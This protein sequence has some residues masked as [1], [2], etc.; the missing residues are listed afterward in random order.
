M[1]RGKR[2]GLGLVD[3]Y[4][5]NLKAKIIAY[6]KI[7]PNTNFKTLL[8]E[9]VRGYNHTF[10]DVIKGSPASLN[11]NFFD[12]VLREMLY[13]NHPRLQ[14]FRSWYHNQ[15]KL[16][17][18]TLKV[19]KGRLRSTDNFRVNDLVLVQYE[20]LTKVQKHHWSQRTERELYRIARVNTIGKFMWQLNKDK[21]SKVQKC[22]WRVRW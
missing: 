19:R 17:K 10:S 4:M 6:L 14:P 3:V 8:D 11:S 5:K 21:I 22:Y 15:L 1:K 20:R 12:P 16:Q 2:P 13:G 7:Y 18:K 9:T